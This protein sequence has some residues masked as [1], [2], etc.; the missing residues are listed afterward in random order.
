MST[1]NL[2]SADYI[3]HHLTHLTFNL[4]TMTFDSNGGF[5]TLNVDTLSISLLLGFLFCGLFYCIACRA[6]AG[7]PSAWQ[8]FV[9]FAV[10]SVDSTVKEIFHGNNP[11][12]GP[13]A[14]TIFAWV[15]LMNFIDLI[16][17]DLPPRLLSFVGVEHYR[18]VATADPNL[19][20]ALSLSVF[21]LILYYNVKIKKLS[22]FTKEV[23]S[24]PFGP[25]LFPLNFSFRLIDELVKPLS[26]SLRLF[27]NLFAGE[28]IFVLIAL[29]PW[30]I[31]WTVGSVWTIFHLLIIA[32]Q[33]YIFMM[34]T[35]VYLSLAHE[36][37]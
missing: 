16:P 36:S 7:I 34:L 6:K 21:G 35:I 30:W 5:W 26:L 31:Q 32:I 4:K 23:F 11:L 25:K 8:N 27:G 33:A 13:I 22:G 2:T 28:L 19:T 17:V 10:D 14:L 15:F 29:L 24:A 20:F 3:Q 37:H 1:E 18:A 9:E 12:I